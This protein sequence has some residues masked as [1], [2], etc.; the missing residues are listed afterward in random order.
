MIEVETMAKYK[1]HGTLYT[2]MDAI[3]EAKDEEEAL[4]L[5]DADKVEWYKVGGDFEHHEDMVFKEVDNDQ[6]DRT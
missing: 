1:L 3:V 2:Y 4:A 5:A 6:A